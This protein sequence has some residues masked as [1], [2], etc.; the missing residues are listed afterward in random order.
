MTFYLGN[1]QIKPSFSS[2]SGK[3]K[4]ITVKNLTNETIPTGSKMWVKYYNLAPINCS[5]G[6][7]TTQE[8]CGYIFPDGSK[9]T[10]TVTSGK[11]SRIIDWSTIP[12]VL[13]AYQS[14]TSYHNSF[15]TSWKY[16]D[17]MYGY[18]GNTETPIFYNILNNTQITMPS[19]SNC[20]YSIPYEGEYIFK[21]YDSTNEDSF[22]VYKPD[23]I[24][25]VVDTTTYIELPFT[26]SS[27]STLKRLSTDVYLNTSTKMIIRIDW[28]NLS[29][30]ELGVLNDYD[31]SSSIYNLSD[32]YIILNK[33]IPNYDYDE[34]H[35]YKI[36][37]DNLTMTEVCASEISNYTTKSREYFGSFK[38]IFRY[39][40]IS[41]ILIIWQE[42]RN[43]TRQPYIALKYNSSNNTWYN[44]TD[45]IL[46]PLAN[47]PEYMQYDS[48]IS[49]WN[50]KSGYQ[51]GLRLFSIS[52]DGKIA[53]SL[54]KA[55]WVCY[56][57]VV[58][59]QEE[60]GYCVLN[61]KLAIND[62]NGFYAIN[63]GA[64]IL[65]NASGEVNILD[66]ASSEE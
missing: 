21:G 7:D 2:N 42:S 29:Y 38:N 20:T 44:I 39:N 63:S 1:K 18:N 34:C 4:T 50:E 28:N 15:F 61:N 31:T 37:I 58:K 35:L 17:K 54:E 26:Q 24:N 43:Y 30:T 19:I 12:A 9:L 46:P 66:E 32:N 25:N 64:D 47:N 33:N 3:S 10:R 45:D 57:L 16:G 6:L 53:V 62:E 14:D 41:K 23:L 49:N 27:A 5:N 65:P 56:S 52:N 60:Y 22:K 48:S 36:D 51:R 55:Y 8:H 40:Y 11:H 59:L 13:G